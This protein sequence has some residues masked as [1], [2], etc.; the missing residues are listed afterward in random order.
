MDSV[1]QSAALPGRRFGVGKGRFGSFFPKT[2][3]TCQHLRFVLYFLRNA[4]IS[5]F[6]KS[7]NYE[8]LEI[9]K[10]FLKIQKKGST[11]NI[12]LDFKE[13][14][15]YLMFNIAYKVV[16]NVDK[17]KLDAYR[18][19]LNGVVRSIETY[20]ASNTDNDYTVYTT[21]TS[22][23]LTEENGRRQQLWESDR[24]NRRRKSP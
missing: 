4:R 1:S 3:E 21:I 8:V 9:T 12:Y 5:V 15:R 19:T 17:A 2:F 22:L 18:S 16:E 24:H 13:D 14:K 6:L 10:D 7:K 11:R 23:N 20:V